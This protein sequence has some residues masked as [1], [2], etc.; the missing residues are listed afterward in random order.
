[1]KSLRYYY[2]IF[3]RP[4]GVFSFLRTFTR[5]QSTVLDVGCGNNSAFLYKRDFPEIFY[6]GLDIGD[7]ENTRFGFE[8]RL[9]ITSPQN[10]SS[11]IKSTKNLDIVISKHNLEHCDEPDQVLENIC[12]S[13]VDGGVLYLAFPS[14]TSTLLP[15]R[16]ITLNF[17]DDPTHNEHPPNLENVIAKLEKNGCEILCVFPKYQPWLLKFIGMLQEPISKA[18][19]KVL[20]GTWAYHGFETVIWAKKKSDF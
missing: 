6:I 5:S 11:A 2:E 10:F 3:L 4:N 16:K 13:L 8:D 1:M 17:Y 9:I 20:Q 15:S 7:Y 12:D 19:G 18:R 14:S